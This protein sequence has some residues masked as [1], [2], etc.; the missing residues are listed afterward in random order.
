MFRAG[1]FSEK[2]YE[3]LTYTFSSDWSQ[4]V[5]LDFDEIEAGGLVKKHEL[6]GIDAVHLSSAIM[7]KGK[8]DLALSFTSFDEKLNR[9]AKAE[10]L[11]VL[12]P[13]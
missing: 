4:F 3:S 10:E 11:E 12:L 9:A 8:S 13:V 5:V 2:D 6:K 1:D 7:M